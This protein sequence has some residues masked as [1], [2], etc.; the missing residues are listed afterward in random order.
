MALKVAT[1]ISELR[2]EPL[3]AELPALGLL[4]VVGDVS[5]RAPVDAARWTAI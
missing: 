5:S 4:T 1:D 2:L 3:S